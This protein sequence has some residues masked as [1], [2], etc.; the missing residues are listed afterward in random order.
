MP[1]GG[2]VNGACCAEVPGVVAVPVDAQ[3]PA[4][5]GSRADRQRVHPAASKEDEDISNLV[6]TDAV[7]PGA[8]DHPSCTP[9]S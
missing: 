1:A 9:S 5:E 7:P 8:H 6:V 4:L 3:L 2:R